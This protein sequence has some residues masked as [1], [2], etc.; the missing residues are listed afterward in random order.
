MGQRR[1]RWRRGERPPLS[2]PTRSESSGTRRI[3]TCSISL[4]LGLFRVVA[5]RGSVSGSAPLTT[6]IVL[7]STLHGPF[8]NIHK[9]SLISTICHSS[10]PPSSCDPVVFLSLLKRRLTGNPLNARITST[11]LHGCFIP[12]MSLS[13][14]NKSDPR[15]GSAKTKVTS[16]K[17][18][19]FSVLSYV[20]SR[21]DPPKSG[22]Y[23]SECSCRN[24]EAPDWA[25]KLSM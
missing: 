4:E 5:H 17:S 11:T 19:L 14:F 8:C 22:E 9:A 24:R 25:A 3:P 12:A 20:Q 13:A 21:P 18:V 7:L 10:A 23:G 2:T 1:K 6:I 15:C 16:A